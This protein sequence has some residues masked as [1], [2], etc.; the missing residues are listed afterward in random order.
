M[1]TLAPTGVSLGGTDTQ[2]SLEDQTKINMFS[3]LNMKFYIKKLKL[4]GTPIRIEFKVG[5]NPF[6]GKRNSLTK[7]QQT[8]KKRMMKFVKKKK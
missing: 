7:R 3:R 4:M 2:I 8:K 6:A 5:D 1:A